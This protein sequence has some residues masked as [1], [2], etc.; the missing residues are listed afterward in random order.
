MNTGNT[1]PYNKGW[2]TVDGIGTLYTYGKPFSY[3]DT[4]CYFDY[5]TNGRFALRLV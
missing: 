3:S 4:S 2:F 1:L 5:I